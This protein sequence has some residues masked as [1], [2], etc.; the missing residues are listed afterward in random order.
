M[1][2]SLLTPQPG[3]RD[4]SL[5]WDDLGPGLYEDE[6]ALVLDSNE[7]IAVSV[8]PKWLENGGGVSFK[9]WARWMEP[10]G[11]TRLCAHGQHIVTSFSCNVDAVLI[12]QHGVEFIA[13][14]L[15]HA[16]LGE[17][18]TTFESQDQE[19][20]AVTLN[21]LMWSDEVLLNASIRHALQSVSH[22]GPM[23]INAANIL[24]L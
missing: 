3:P 11:Q 19:G 18:L 6:T 22:T 15:L 4:E 17:P 10:N 16:L 1:A 24:G 9:G 12:E 7:L 2:Y 13:K 20:N 21:T 14:E 8:V 5:S 23:A